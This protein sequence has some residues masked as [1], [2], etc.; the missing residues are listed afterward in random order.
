MPAQ[1]RVRRDE[2]ADLFQ[3][4]ATE[5]FAFDRQAPPLV[6]IEQDAALGE[7]LLEHL[8]LGTQVFDHLL[9]LTIHPA[10]Q[11]HEQKLPRLPWCDP[12]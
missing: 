12:C 6:V 5:H 11:D 4:L 1:N 3:H 10:G 8:I 7:L 2:S 9:L